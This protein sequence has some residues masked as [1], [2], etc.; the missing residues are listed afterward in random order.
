MNNVFFYIALCATFYFAG[1]RTEKDPVE[2]GSVCTIADG[3]GKF[4]LVKVLA[5]DDSEVHLMMFKKTYD[6]RPEKIGPED[7]ELGLMPQNEQ[8][9]EGDTH[10]PMTRTEFEG[11]K[12]V[13]V[14]FE[15][16][17]KE[18]LEGYE[19]WKAGQSPAVP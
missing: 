19:Q 13:V 6:Q 16:I 14:A 17:V 8:Q 3:Y 18:D 12:P 1:C 4:R 2:P 5:A 7:L 11:H 9:G 10:V 15:K